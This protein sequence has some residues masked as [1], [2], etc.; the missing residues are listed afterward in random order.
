MISES[1]KIYIIWLDFEIEQHS[2]MLIPVKRN[3]SF[4]YTYVYSFSIFILIISEYDNFPHCN[5]LKISGVISTY[6]LLNSPISLL[7]LKQDV[8]TCT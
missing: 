4:G 3:C 8:A 1:P 5:R 2:C 6:D 7:A